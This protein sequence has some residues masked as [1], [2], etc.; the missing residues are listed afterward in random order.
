MESTE[1]LPAEASIG[2]VHLT[3]GDPASMMAFYRDTLGFAEAGQTG[4]THLLSS[5]GRPPF[6]VM[7]TGAPTATPRPPRS[8]GLYHA[9]FLLPTRADLGR[10]L[11][12]V[13]ES[14]WPLDGASDHGVSEALYLRDPEGN[15]IEIYSDRPPDTWPVRSGAV[16]MPTKG[17]DVEDVL[18]AGVGRWEGM[19]SGARV[20]HVHL[21]VRDLQQ[22]EAF[23]RGVLG[24]D[25]TVRTY[26]GALFLSAGG[27]H[28]HLGLNIWGSPSAPAAA[29]SR[30]LRSFSIRLPDRAALDAAV[31]RVRAAGL[32]VRAVDHGSS[33]AAYVQDPDG[34]TCALALD[35]PGHTGWREEPIDI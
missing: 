10:L 17:L 23:Y 13:L 21:K 27:Y 28:H 2:S 16:V 7:L 4:S 31:A 20:G 15:G 29:G 12:H 35:V 5:T 22:S 34:I 8:A 18:A 6:H 3:V 11:R 25:V 33:V 14:E 26:P 1:R 24:F 30:G 9:A 32:P 19:P